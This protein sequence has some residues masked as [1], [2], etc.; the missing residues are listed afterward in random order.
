V[1]TTPQGTKYLRDPIVMLI[2]ETRIVV[3]TGLKQVLMDI[4]PEFIHGYDDLRMAEALRPSY[5]GGGGLLTQFAGQMCYLALGKKRTPFSDNKDYIEKILASGHGSVTEHVNYS[6][7]FFGIDRA[8]THELVRHRAGMAYSQVSQ[9]YVGPE[10][11][12]FVMPWEDQKDEYL[13]NAFERSIDRAREEYAVRVEDL[14]RVT[15]RKEGESNTDWRKRIQ[16]SAR[17]TLPN[18]TEAPMVVT[19]NG[20]S[21]RHVFSMRCSPFADVRIRRPMVQALRTLQNVA[22]ALFSDWEFKDLPDGTETAT[23]RHPKP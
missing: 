9:R 18:S 16:S 8:C 6:L 21:W 20:R 15:P 23:A 12:R 5:D 2:G 4:D 1:N 19:G 3:P 13:T 10:H 22:P 11:V 14:K 17:S 7:A